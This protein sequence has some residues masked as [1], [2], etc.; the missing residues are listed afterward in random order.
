MK[1]DGGPVFTP[2]PSP[3]RASR[4]APARLSQADPPL[5]IS[6]NAT[7]SD[8][9]V[10]TLLFGSQSNDPARLVPLTLFKNIG[11]TC[12]WPSSYFFWTSWVMSTSY[13]HRM[14]HMEDFKKLRSLYSAYEIIDTCLFVH[15]CS[16]NVSNWKYL[17]NFK[18]ID[19]NLWTPV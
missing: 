9:P 19:P 6:R 15:T 1:T 12:S 4:G 8:A 18:N 2:Q 10:T 17:K 13:P 16:K 3:A 5:H 11:T 7:F 14:T